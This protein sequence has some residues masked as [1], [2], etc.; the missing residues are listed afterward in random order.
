MN[1]PADNSASHS[2]AVRV[3]F[4]RI[5]AFLGA[6][7][8]VAAAL[9]FGSA[10]DGLVHPGSDLDLAVLFEQHLEAEEFLQFYIDLCERLPEVETVDLIRLN[11]A[12]PILAFEALNGR[13]LCMNN[14][15]AMATCFSLVCRE[16][17]DVMASLQDQQRRAA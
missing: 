4:S 17:E 8:R 15:E 1:S 7:S 10:Q 16:Y 14:Q 3:D 13:Y 2:N 6:D 11:Q 12:N 5:K 9:A